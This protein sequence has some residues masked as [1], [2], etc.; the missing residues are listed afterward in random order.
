MNC[1]EWIA[2][3]QLGLFVGDEKIEELIVQV[4]TE[5]RKKE[6]KDL[7]KEDGRVS[8]LELCEKRNS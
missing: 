7:D 3:N 4:E 6:G 5:N 1:V 8:M 2:L